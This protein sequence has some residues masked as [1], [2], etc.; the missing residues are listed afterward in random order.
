V[1]R[2]RI[3]F[4]T[5]VFTGSYNAIVLEISRYYVQE[6]KKFLKSRKKN[7]IIQSDIDFIDVVPFT[8]RISKD[9]DAEMAFDIDGCVD[10]YDHGNFS[11]VIFSIIINNKKFP[12]EYNNF[13][14]E[15]KDTIRHE[16]EHV[17]QFNNTNK[18]EDLEL[19]IKKDFLKINDI[20]S[21]DESYFSYVLEYPEL[22]AYVYGFHQKAKTMKVSMNTIIEMWLEERKHLFI[23]EI[24]INTV[25]EKF[26]ELGKKLLPK[27][28]WD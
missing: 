21:D 20:E 8:V 7:I 28:K 4:A 15:F 9:P 3:D 26:I 6:L 2:K 17:S 16:I 11:Y 12:L 13:I 22:Y 24:E 27:A 10:N 25:R 19:I 1:K 5:F 23:N 14:A 18:D